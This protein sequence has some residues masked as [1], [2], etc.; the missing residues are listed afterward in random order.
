MKKE[1]LNRGWQFAD[2]KSQ[3]KWTQVNLPHD[4]MLL[5]KRIPNIV[6]GA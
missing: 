1:S 5:E 4:A 3:S 6:N 2:I